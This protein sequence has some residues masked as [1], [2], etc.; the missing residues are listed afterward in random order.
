MLRRCVQAAENPSKKTDRHGLRGGHADS[1]SG[2]T[3][4]A[5]SNSGG[6][7]RAALTARERF[8]H[9]RNLRSA[10]PNRGFAR[11]THPTASPQTG[12]VRKKALSDDVLQ[13]VAVDV[14][15]A[16]VAAL[17]ADGHAFVIDAQQVQHG[18]VHVMNRD[19]VFDGVVTEFV[20]RPVRRA[21]F[22]SAASH[23]HRISLDVVIATTALSHRSS[24]KLAGPDHEGVFQKVALFEVG[25]QRGGS[26]IAQFRGI[27]RRRLDVA[28][29]IPATMV[30]LNESNS[31]FGKASSQQAVRRE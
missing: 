22:D 31:A 27:G 2:G 7:A 12:T 14:G 24:A 4:G 23:P 3:S 8:E 21:A 26:L 17:E 10:P 30:E 1:P 25:Q 20:G 9:S 18:C 19:D 11:L 15:Q 5:D 13:D 28:V 6:A 16:E 29:M